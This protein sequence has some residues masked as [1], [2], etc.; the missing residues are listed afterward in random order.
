MFKLTSSTF[1]ASVFLLT[2]SLGG[3]YSREIIPLQESGRPYEV[4]G[5]QS[6]K[7][8]HMPTGSVHAILELMHHNDGNLFET[9]YFSRDSGW[10]QLRFAHSSLCLDVTNNAGYNG[11][12]VQEYECNHGDNQRWTVRE[13]SNGNYEIIAAGANKC[14]DVANQSVGDKSQ[15]VIF[16]CNNQANQEWKLVSTT[17]TFPPATPQPTHEEPQPVPIEKKRICVGSAIDSGWVLVNKYQV[18]GC[19]GLP[20]DPG[21]FNEW[22]IQRYDNRPP[23]DTISACLGPV[24]QNWT[25]T[26][27]SFSTTRCGWSPFDGSRDNLMTIK[28]KPHVERQTFPGG[29]RPPVPVKKTKH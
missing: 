15:V 25:R 24:P 28:R 11:A 13:K 9:I 1:I 29:R 2:L 10:W 17:P 26:D 18:T 6:G 19:G 22:E 16:T 23:N 3:A 8:L 20:T 7:S 12:E 14:L 21:I 5:I 4:I 27:T